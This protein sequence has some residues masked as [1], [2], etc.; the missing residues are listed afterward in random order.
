VRL[1]HLVAR[2][3]R[4][5]ADLECQPPA[6]GAVLLGANAQGKTNFLEAV[7]YPVLFRSF[8][9]AA[10]AEV[11]RFNG[12]GFHLEVGLE[13]AAARGVSATFHAAR[14]KKR[15][16]LDGEE[17]ARLA[18]VVG[19]WLAVA[20]LP[21]DVGLAS[22]AAAERRQYLD[23]LLSLADPGYLRALLRYRA[24]LAQRNGALRQ[25][26]TEVARA[27]DA[28]LTAAGAEVV[29]AREVWAAAAA[30]QF[31]AELEWVAEPESVRLRYR[32]TAGLAD[33]AA[34]TEVLERALPADRARGIT[35]VGPH[36]DDLVLEVGGRPLRDFG[37][38]G[39]QR[40]A[41]VA[42]KLIEIATLR[43]SRG[44][45]PALLLDDVF[46]ELD[47]DRQRRLGRRLLDSGERQVF[48][49]AP[50]PDELPP[51]LELPVWEMKEGRVRGGD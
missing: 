24:A 49:T 43:D 8:R 44:T 1:Q 11:A 17:P 33:P 46:A 50:R 6:G 47:R 22:G 34:W 41:A 37:S 16:T 42:L 28:P 36:R 45:E 38:T 40:S 18:D 25:G 9:G 39:Q 29:R 21:A 30:E 15:I 23:R 32:G 14:R 35:T 12:P 51:D 10:D 2:D 20:F 5:L 48:L 27:F 4:N 3:F 7:Y 31:A 19:A 13:G 26:R